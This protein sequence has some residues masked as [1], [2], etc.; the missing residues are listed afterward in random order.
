MPKHNRTRQRAAG[1]RLS[2]S[3]NG[4][5]A[6]AVAPTG[7]ERCAGPIAILM[8]DF[9]LTHLNRLYQ[10][11]DGDLLLP[12]VLGEI[13]H[14]NVSPFFTAR[15]TSGRQADLRGF[16][17]KPGVKGMLH[18]CNAFALSTATGIPRETVRRKI[19]QLVRLGY[20]RQD[21][22]GELFL[23]KKPER[24]FLPEFNVITLNRLLNLARRI[25]GMLAEAS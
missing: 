25:E 8:A 10:S 1:G 16:W 4:T 13:A 7:Y 19:A 15:G 20:V 24:D 22:K 5:A 14:H 12:I 21:K 6:L 17:D 3:D 23:T 18:G 2:T 9:F 11:F